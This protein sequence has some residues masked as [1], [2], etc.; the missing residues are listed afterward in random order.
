MRKQIG[1]PPRHAWPVCWTDSIGDKLLAILKSLIILSILDG[2]GHTY[3]YGI[4]T[5]MVYMY[6]D[7]YYILTGCFLNS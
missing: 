3:L 7:T 1:M 6:A 2:S 5:E 4:R